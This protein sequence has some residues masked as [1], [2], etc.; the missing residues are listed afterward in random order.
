MFATGRIIAPE[1]GACEACSL[2]DCPFVPGYGPDKADI[3]LLGEAPGYNEVRYGRPFVGKAGQL[4]DQV[5]EKAGIN[6]DDCFITNACLCRPE[7]NRTPKAD[8]IRACRPRLISEILSR[9]P[10][11]ILALG[12]IALRALLG[13]CKTSIKISK[14]RGAPFWSEEFKAWVVPSYHPAAVL[15]NGNLY[16]D[17]IKDVQSVTGLFKSKVKVGDP[18]KVDFK[19]LTNYEDI[20]SLVNEI[21]DVKEVAVDTEWSS[22]NELL[23]I[24]ISWG[25]T[26]VITRSALADP[27]TKHILNDW[28]GRLKLIGQNFKSDLQRLWKYGITSAR[29]GQD[30]ML[31]HYLSLI[32]I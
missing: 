30:T 10:K 23:C 4:L 7:D 19:L 25:P 11:V 9:E 5:L 27:R 28:F 13:S 20:Y 22:K 2:A 32:H 18:N 8:E 29:V 12:N 26:V 31:M 3:I 6:R 21:L 14:M 24:G 1:G 15:R 17:L 16:P